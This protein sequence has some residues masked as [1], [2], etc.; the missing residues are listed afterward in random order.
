MW[1]GGSLYFS[2]EIKIKLQW[3]L[4]LWC[5]WVTLRKLLPSP[6]CIS[7]WTESVF[8]LSLS[9]SLTHT[10]T[11]AGR[12]KNPNYCPTPRSVTREEGKGQ[13]SGRTPLVLACPNHGFSGLEGLYRSSGPIYRQGS[14]AEKCNE[15]VTELRARFGP[16]HGPVLR[17]LPQCS[18]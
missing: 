1:L 14:R 2:S 9:P 11:I 5:V 12:K 13:R 18:G 10:Q 4:L 8:L 16:M 6:L 15:L 7:T 3:E 17:K